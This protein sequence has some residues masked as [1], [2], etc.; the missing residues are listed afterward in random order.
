M[1]RLAKW[2]YSSV[3]LRKNLLFSY[4]LVLLPILLLGVYSYNYSRKSFLQQTR[5]SMKDVA[6]S[7]RAGMENSISRENDNIRYLTYNTELRKHLENIE[8]NLNAFTK[9]LSEDVEPIFWYFITSDNNLDWI[10]IYSPYLHKNI[11]DFCLDSGSVEKE[12][13]YQE[14]LTNFKTI[15]K[16]EEDRIY[17]RRSLLDIGSSSRA[18][19]LIELELDMEK[20]TEPIRY[21]DKEVSGTLLLDDKGEIIFKTIYHDEELEKEVENFIL[22]EKP[23][24]FI[25]TD[26]FLISDRQEISN[27]WKL[28]YFR[29]QSSI[30]LQLKEIQKTT[31]FLMAVSFI[32]FMILGLLVSKILSNRILR[33]KD[34]AEEISRGNFNVKMDLRYNDE[35]GIVNKSF[36]HMQQKM[37]EMIKKTYQLGMEKRKEELIALQAKINPHFLYNCLSSIKWKAIKNGNDDIAD[38]TGFLA[39]FYRS[40]LNGGKAITTVENE[41]ETIKAYLEL[42]KNFHDNSFDSFIYADEEGKY[43]PVPNFLLQPLVENAILHGVDTLEGE[44]TRGRVEVYYRLEEEHIVFQVKN[45]GLPMDKE[46]LRGMLSR[47]FGGYGLYYIRERIRLYYDDARCGLS[48]DIDEKGMVCFT[49]RLGRMLKSMDLEQD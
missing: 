18:I 7:M 12:S 14:S 25:H 4:C 1:T 34:A 36:N 45:N 16:F 42:Q 8:K 6:A 32:V 39:K 28:Y 30:E 15:W 17:A 29:D 13:W 33:L 19:G 48:T 22:K 23:E 46:V 31:I 5:L 49:V 44:D 38:I 3:N 24:N 26:N 10:H 41:L 20:M 35:I 9:T 37:N 40:T 2:Y 27:G 47:P 43:L 11:G 21:I